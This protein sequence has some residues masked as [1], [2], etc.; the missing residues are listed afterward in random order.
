M[1][2][3]TTGRAASAGC[4]HGPVLT[5]SAHSQTIGSHPVGAALMRN[6]RPEI[7]NVPITND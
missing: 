1:F 6:A 3:A 7:G 2:D 4:T 5:V